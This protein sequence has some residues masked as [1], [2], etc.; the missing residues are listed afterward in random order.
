MC[1]P[2]PL[3]DR[4][5]DRNIAVTGF[6][7]IVGG[8]SPGGDS[9]INAEHRAAYA[10]RRDTQSDDPHTHVDQ[11]D[12]GHV[13]QQTIGGVGGSVPFIDTSSRDAANAV[14]IRA[15]SDFNMAVHAV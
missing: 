2:R 4:I 7:V 13:V 9:P 15:R 11:A 3:S 14:A 8:T 12:H 6:F 10:P 5:F 1:R